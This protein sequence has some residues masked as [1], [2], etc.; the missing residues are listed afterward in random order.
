MADEAQLQLADSERPILVDE[1]IEEL[2]K[3]TDYE[4][5]EWPIGVLVEKF[6]NG[7]E[8]DESEIFIPDYP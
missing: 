4:I 8:K 7:R 5:K 2:Q 3:I 1:Q 6:T